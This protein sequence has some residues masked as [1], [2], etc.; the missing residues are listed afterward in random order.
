MVQQSVVSSP[1]PV[2]S[3]DASIFFV[4]AAIGLALTIACVFSA[5]PRADTIGFVLAP[6]LCLTLTYEN[7]ALASDALATDGLVS[8]ETADGAL[9]LRGAVQAFVI[10]LWLTALF[11]ITYTVHKRRSANFLLGLFTFDQGHRRR[12]S[13]LSNGLRYSLWVLGCA[14]LLIQITLNGPYM[15]APRDAPRVSRFSFK[16]VPLGTLSA[17]AIDWQDAVDLVPWLVFLAWALVAGASLWRYGT[18]VSTD[19]NATC[20]NAWGLLFV[21]AALLLAA[22]VVSPH[23]WPYPYGVNA[24][25]LGLAAATA[26]SMHLIESNLKTLENWDRILTIAG[27]A[28]TE[29][30][31][32]RR[33]EIAQGGAHRRGGGGGGGSTARASLTAP[34]SCSPRPNSSPPRRAQRNRRTR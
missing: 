8:R 6:L 29:A 3:R 22:W 32:Q 17:P 5:R 30:L 7:L 24:A 11:E 2:P 26:V 23:A 10:P 14:L 9:K 21:A 28:V 33:W 31:A 13:A 12:T 15:A 1:A 34:K 16:G 18:L 25:E 19:I 4:Y 20:V 27:H